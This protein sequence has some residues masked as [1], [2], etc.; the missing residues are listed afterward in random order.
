MNSWLLIDCALRTTAMLVEAKD[1]RSRLVARGEARTTLDPEGDVRLGVCA[2]VRQLEEAA[3]RPLLRPDGGGVI[4]PRDAAGNGVDQILISS[5]VGGGLQMMVAGLVRSMTAESAERAALGAGANVLDVI[6]ID[7]GRLPHERIDRMRELRPDMFLLGGGVNEGNRQEV[8]EF[9]R[10]VAQADVPHMPV[11]FAGNEALQPTVLEALGERTEVHLVKNM[12][13]KLEQEVLEPTRQKIHELFM[14]HVVSRAPGFAALST[15]SDQPIMPSPGAVS[16]LVEVVA[17]RMQQNLLEIVV[18]DSTTDVCS[19]FDGRF[20]R[21]VSADLGLGHSL[22]SVAVKAGRDQLMRW[23]PFS[24]QRDEL[25]NYLRNL[26]LRTPTAPT[27]DRDL[28]IRQAV[29]REAMRLALAEHKR[30]A[31]RLRGVHQARDIASIFEKPADSLVQMS[32]LQLIIAAASVFAWGDDR[33]NLEL[34]LDALRPEGITR[35]AI[36]PSM[37]APQLGW[38]ATVNAAVGYEV[39]LQDGLR[40]LGVAVCPSGHIVA[41]QPCLQVKLTANDGSESVTQIVGGRVSILPVAEGTS[42]T[43]EPGRGLD[44]GAG[45]GRPRTLTMPASRC[46]LIFDTRKRVQK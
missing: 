11:V 15:W 42:V 38:L 9:I 34:L 37:T 18:G 43:I 2:A 10:E 12:R 7:D 26:S 40:H 27:D 19:V 30:R 25:M 33:A 23:L 41:N 44:V 20:N 46:G 31:S 16:Q 28:A 4:R 36:D 35:L 24:L 21:T 1:G 5:S 8:F 13:P 29:A 3:G 6:A 14:R 45:V 22:A 17:A 39:Y 32:Q